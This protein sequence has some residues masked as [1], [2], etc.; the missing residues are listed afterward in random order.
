MGLVVADIVKGVLS[1]DVAG[2]TKPV[3]YRSRQLQ[4][5]QHQC[6]SLNP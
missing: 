1:F 5:I 3:M 6:Q 4:L 2:T